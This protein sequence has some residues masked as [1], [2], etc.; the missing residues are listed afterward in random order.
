V[1]RDGYVECLKKGL[2]S[3]F[4]NSYDAFTLWKLVM[5]NHISP[6]SLV[7]G[8]DWKSRKSQKNESVPPVFSKENQLE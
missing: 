6:S 2:F 5:F 3:H 1:K 7:E 4:V 8:K